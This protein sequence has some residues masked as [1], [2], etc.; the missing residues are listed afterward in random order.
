[1]KNERDYNIYKETY[2]E[3]FERNWDLKTIFI[4][5]DQYTESISKGLLSFDST[6]KLPIVINIKDPFE[7]ID[8]IKS[9]ADTSIILLDNYFPWKWYEEPLWDLFRLKKHIHS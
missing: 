5:E 2:S 9:Q 3:I 4:L 1:M 8:I 6:L 7:Y